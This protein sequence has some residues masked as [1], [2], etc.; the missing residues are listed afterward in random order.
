MA[1]GITGRIDKAV[2]VKTFGHQEY[3]RSIVIDYDK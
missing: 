3:M 1:G 2:K